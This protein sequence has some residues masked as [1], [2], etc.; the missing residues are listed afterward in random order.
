MQLNNGKWGLPVVQFSETGVPP[1]L[2]RVLRAFGDTDPWVLLATLLSYD[3]GDGRISDWIHRN[4]RI[5]DAIAIARSYG[6][7]EVA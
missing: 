7:Q 5:E 3:Y 1:V 6:Q 2:P 4:I